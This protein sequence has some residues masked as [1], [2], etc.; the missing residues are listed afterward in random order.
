MKTKRCS[1]CQVV[2][3]AD[4]FHRDKRLSTGLQ[5]QCKAC[6]KEY[7]QRPENKKRRAE[8]DQRQI[9]WKAEVVKMIANERMDKESC[10]ANSRAVMAKVQVARDRARSIEDDVANEITLINLKKHEDSKG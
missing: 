5:Y 1:K 8:Y 2:K 9:A 7:R 6:A 10:I 3:L 4:Q